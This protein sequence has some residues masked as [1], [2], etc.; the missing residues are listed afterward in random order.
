MSED[1]KLS[2]ILV[3]QLHH[4]R[5]YFVTVSAQYQHSV[6]GSSFIHL[7]GK[8]KNETSISVDLVCKVGGRIK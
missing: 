6:F 1:G 8:E 5:H 4:G 7:I 2:E 3:L